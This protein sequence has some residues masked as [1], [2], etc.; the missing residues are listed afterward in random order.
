VRPIDCLELYQDAEFYDLEFADRAREIPF[1]RRFAQQA[2]GPVL[3]V[4]CGT[5]RLTLPIAHDGI[6][7]TGLDVSLPML[8]RARAKAEKAS[9]TVKWVHGDCREMPFHD[10]FDLVFSATNA[11]QHLHDL[12][13]VVAFL[14]SARRAL[15]ANGRLIIDVFNPDVTKLT[16]PSTV[17]YLHKT[18]STPTG[19]TIRVEASS[20]YR[21]Q[22]QILHF[23]LFYV[24]NGELLRTKHVDMRCFFPEE[25]MALFR[26][27]GFEV[28]QRFGD[29]DQSPY[30]AASPKQVLLCRKRNGST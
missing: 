7:V 23:D 20:H 22:E 19:D 14:Q 6:E 11:M 13:S 28:V 25:L 15:R 30:T 1:F 27:S 8:N 18:L 24:L 26:F 16:R 17:R 4:A 12:D 3:E 5:G 2:N 21:A 29:Y 9:L 10:A